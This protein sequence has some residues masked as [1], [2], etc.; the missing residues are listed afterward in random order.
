MVIMTTETEV[1]RNISV[2]SRESLATMD[3]VYMTCEKIN[4][5]IISSQG[6]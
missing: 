1:A 3:V 6:T 5:N 4:F 2:E